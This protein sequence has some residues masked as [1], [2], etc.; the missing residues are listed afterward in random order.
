MNILNMKKLAA[1]AVFIAALTSPLV[2]AATLHSLNG[3]QFKE[4]FI[5]KTF[6]SIATDNLNG[7]TIDNTF[8]MFMDKHGNIFGKMSHKPDNQPQIDK[9]TY[10]VEADGTIYITWQHWDGAKAVCG[11]VFNTENAYISVDCSNVFH[12]A[13]MKE[14]VKPGNV[15]Y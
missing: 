10:I 5:G 2:Y 4:A 9:G 14:A 8:S 11:R 15:L 12:T 13:F 3:S 6:T 7:R 1:I